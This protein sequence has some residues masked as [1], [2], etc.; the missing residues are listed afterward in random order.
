MEMEQEAKHA[1]K[2]KL[3]RFDWSENENTEEKSIEYYKD[4]IKTLAAENM[5]LK[6]MI[7]QADEQIAE[8]NDHDVQ[9]SK[10]IEKMIGEKDATIKDK[11]KMLSYAKEAIFR[12]AI[13]EVVR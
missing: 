4:R 2:E 10:Y 9:T 12:A 6:E 13:R 7:R 11:D 3:A 8:H 5:K 1:K